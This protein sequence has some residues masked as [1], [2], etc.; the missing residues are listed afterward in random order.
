MTAGLGKDQ[1]HQAREYPRDD[2]VQPVIEDLAVRF[3]NLR[4]GD[5]PF[6]E[7]LSQ[8]PSVGQE[9]NARVGMEHF[10]RARGQGYG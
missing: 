3:S 8:V 2:G 5:F 4:G 7:L 1:Q 6:S 9:P 10:L